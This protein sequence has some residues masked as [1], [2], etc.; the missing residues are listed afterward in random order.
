MTRVLERKRS[1]SS[2]MPHGC[3]TTSR[4]ASS[5]ERFASAEVRQAMAQ[6]IVIDGRNLLDPIA[7]REAGFVYEGI[8]RAA[9]PLG[10]LPE[11]AE[12]DAELAE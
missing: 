1:S 12:R 3:S 6:P 2:S 4:S 8:G 5:S 11:T 9:S 10:A 7:A